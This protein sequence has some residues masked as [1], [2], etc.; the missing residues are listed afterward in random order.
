[1]DMKGFLRNSIVAMTLAHT[2]IAVADAVLDWNEIAL[3]RVSA[4]RQL[5]PDAARTM[6]IVHV[7]MFDAINAIERRY[8]PYSYD[9]PPIEGAALDAA[10]I[11]AAHATL[12]RLFPAEV[13][14]LDAAYAASL[15]G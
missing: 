15:A 4:A 7:A 1:M 3:A 12:S 10:A 13:Q 11:A 5:P 8:R 6:A 9:G 14:S 2:P